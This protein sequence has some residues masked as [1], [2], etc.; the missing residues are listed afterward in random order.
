YSVWAPI[1]SI[2][3]FSGLIRVHATKCSASISRNCG[4]TREHS[5]IAYGQRVRKR[6]PDGGFTGDG[7]SPRKIIRSAGR[8]K[9]GT[10]AISALVYG[11]S[12]R[13]PSFSAL[14]S[15]TIS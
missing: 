9:D 13:R 3:G 10:A 14:A 11:I 15:S 4:R 8:E 1:A 7:I 12:G 6:H 2:S 5:S